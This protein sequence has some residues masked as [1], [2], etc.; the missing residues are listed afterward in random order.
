MQN[1]ILLFGGSSEERL[2]S[3]ASAQNIA[4]RYPFSEICFIHKDGAL[5][6]VSKD[7]LLFH[8]NAFQV[9]FKPAAKPFASSIESA[10][11]FLKNKVVFLGLHGTE[12]EDGTIQALFEKA[13]IQ[14]TG[15]GSESS[16]NAFNKDKAKSIVAKVGVN[17]A[18]QMIVNV[19]ASG[20]LAPSLKAF[21]QT[22]GKIVL[23]P[24]ANG[25]S[26]G[27]FIVSD[28]SALE[29]AMKA[30]STLNYGSYLAEKFMVGRELTVAVVDDG[31]GPKALP[32]SEVL[33][34]S[35]HSFDYQGKYLGK[36][37]TEV[38]PAEISASE[39]KAAQELALA[40]HQALQCYGYTRTD[41]MLTADGPVFME[42]NTLPGLTKASFVPQQ[43]AAAG[44]DFAAFIEG[45]LKRARER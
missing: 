4:N 36:G 38:T 15:S 17:M 33:L 27:L 22:H 19:S 7:E 20:E 9:E 43:L 42:T 32:A 23:K 6:L 35:G 25:S 31:S 28:L 14:F 34:S 5:S 45:Q 8:Q 24:L 16:A 41:M 10:L 3:V 21:F 29:S 2:V 37:T 30:I 18:P 40:A 26:I 13:Q 11:P 44:M 12:G 1:T 39:M